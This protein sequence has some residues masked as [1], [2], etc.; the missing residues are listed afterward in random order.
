MAVPSPETSSGLTKWS[1][2]S[3]TSITTSRSERPIWG[4]ASPTP[5]AA[6][7]VSS[8]S[9]RS[10]TTRLVILC[11]GCAFCRNTG[12]PLNL[13]SRTANPFHPFLTVGSRL[14]FTI[15]FLGLQERHRTDIHSDRHAIRAVGH[16]GKTR[17]RAPLHNR[18]IA[19]KEKV[20]PIFT[21]ELFQRGRGRADQMFPRIDNISATLG[22]S[23][24]GR[25][26]IPLV[27][28]PNK[29]ASQLGIWWVLGMLSVPKLLLCKTFVV[30]CRGGLDRVM[31]G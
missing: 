11:T 3:P 31:I 12:S 28:S 2:P 1:G 27:L 20:P 14:Y 13:I 23:L 4:A 24:R 5:S 18:L 30:V 15:T 25:R 9:C 22:R 16:G 21:L 19:F 10:F 17:L 6:Y 29:Y 7:M 26:H 8:I